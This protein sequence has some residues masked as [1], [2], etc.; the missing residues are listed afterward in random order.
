[1]KREVTTLKRQHT[2]SPNFETLK[3]DSEENAA[4]NFMVSSIKKLNGR[5]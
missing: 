3:S 1:M 4:G 2:E 5:T